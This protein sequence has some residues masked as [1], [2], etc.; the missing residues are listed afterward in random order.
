[1]DRGARRVKCFPQPAELGPPL[2]AR[3]DQD[4]D[5]NAAADGSCDLRDDLIVGAAEER[6]REPAARVTNRVQHRVTPLGW[7]RDDT[8]GPPA[9]ANGA[10]TRFGRSQPTPLTPGMLRIWALRSSMEVRGSSQV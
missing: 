10:H 8:L 5:M 9:R 7:I 4:V 3:R 1:M 6:Q 2:G